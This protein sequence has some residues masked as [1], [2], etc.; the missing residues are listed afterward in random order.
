MRAGL[1]SALRWNKAS[2]DWNVYVLT[3]TAHPLE[4][5]AASLTQENNSVITTATLIDDLA[6]DERSLQIFVKRMLGSKNGSRLL[7]VVDQFEELF[8]LCRS[9]QERTSFIGNL[10]TAASETDG[11]V[12]V[13]ITLRADFYASCANYPHLREALAQTPGIYWRNE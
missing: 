12:I 6:G 3:P 9:E 4:S 5:L 1:V 8:A 13:V 11:P 2:T 10:L 7:L